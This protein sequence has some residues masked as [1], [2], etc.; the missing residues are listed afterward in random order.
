MSLDVF[1][2]SDGFMYFVCLNHYNLFGLKLIS[3]GSNGGFFIFVNL[4]SFKPLIIVH[5]FEIIPQK[6]TIFP[7][8]VFGIVVCVQLQKLDDKDYCF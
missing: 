4:G 1:L 5:N 2:W 6:L 8:F 3:D 7:L